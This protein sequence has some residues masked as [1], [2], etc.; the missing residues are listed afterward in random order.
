MLVHTKHTNKHTPCEQFVCVRMLFLRDIFNLF[1][2]P[3][4][5]IKTSVHF[6][7][8]CILSFPLI[9]S[10]LLSP[11]RAGVCAVMLMIFSFLVQI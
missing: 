7:F 2:P 6:D 3:L 10:F 5:S 4:D 1:Y 11:H 8:V 9:R